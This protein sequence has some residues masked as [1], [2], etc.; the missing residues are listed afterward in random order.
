MFWNHQIAK[1]NTRKIFFFPIAKFNAFKVSTNSA[2]YDKV[3]KRYSISSSLWVSIL[4]VCFTIFIKVIFSIFCRR[5]QCVLRRENTQNC[6]NK[7]ILGVKFSLQTHSL[8][9]KQKI[10]GFS[11]KYKHLQMST[12][13]FSEC[14]FMIVCDR[15]M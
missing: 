6:Q 15:S 1:L 13:V 2:S 4:Q 9:Q 7:V 11:G 14:Y 5:S 10:D 3:T 8:S 12:P